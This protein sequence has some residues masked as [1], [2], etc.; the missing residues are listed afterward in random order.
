[1]RT[2]IEVAVT[3]WDMSRFLLDA[4]PG[5]RRVKGFGLSSP[6]QLKSK[7]TEGIIQYSSPLAICDLRDDG[8]A[9][10]NL[11]MVLEDDSNPSPESQAA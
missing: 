9:R 11:S 5:H 6:D 4:A 10:R 3:E 2:T 7:Y 1:M 8:L